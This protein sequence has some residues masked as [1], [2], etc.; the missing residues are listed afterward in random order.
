MDRKDIH[1]G[2]RGRIR[3]RFAEQ[4]IDAF[5]DHEVLELLLTYAIP[6]RDV[7]PIAHA[8]IDTFGSISNVMEAD[9]SE[10][11]RVEGVGEQAA[12]LLRM[13]PPL[14]RRYEKSALGERPLLDTYGRAKAYCRTLF[15][16]MREEHIYLLCLDAGGRLVHPVLLRKGTFD[17]VSI[18]PREVLEAVIRH[19]ASNVILAHNHP[20]G[21]REPSAADYRAT[22][23]ISLA[24]SVIAVKV[25]DHLVCAGEDVF[26]MTSR[27][28]RV[29]PEALTYVTRNRG[30]CSAQVKE[31]DLFHALD[32][33]ALRTLWEA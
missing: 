20:G 19:K 30:T 14:L 10:L 16:G 21:N 26:S 23:M 32:L 11:M 5:A 1:A 24:L 31:E 18:Y 7:N 8:L 13:M 6:R 12:L 33:N 27:A 15:C 29:E 3:E 17:E 2:H 22:E 28:E 9:S 4:G 25:I